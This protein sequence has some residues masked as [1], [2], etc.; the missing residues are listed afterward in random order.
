MVRA[1]PGLSDCPLP[2]GVLALDNAGS[3]TGES[4]LGETRPDA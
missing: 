1:G 4:M 3:I 2:E